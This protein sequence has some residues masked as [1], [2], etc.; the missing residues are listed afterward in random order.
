MDQLRLLFRFLLSLPPTLLLILFIVL[1]FV[2][3]SII[4]SFLSSFVTLL[5]LYL[6][7]TNRNRRKNALATLGIVERGKEG[8]VR[9]KIVGFFHPYWF[10]RRLASSCRI[11][12]DLLKIL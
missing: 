6:R 7:S 11:S 9:K 10:V 12:V 5:G 8:E 3:I 2:V 4:Y 1:T